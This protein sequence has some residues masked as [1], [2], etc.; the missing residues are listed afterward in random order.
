[1]FFV[2]QSLYIYP[3]TLKK[4]KRRKSIEYYCEHLGN[5]DKKMLR[6]VNNAY[7]ILHLCGYYDGIL[8]V[9]VVTA[10][11]DEAYGII[12]KIKPNLH[13]IFIRFHSYN[14]LILFFR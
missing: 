14:S 8:D 13:E 12:D 9:R 5:I 6:Q 11:L 10:G 4:T 2:F 1:V 3:V 7:E